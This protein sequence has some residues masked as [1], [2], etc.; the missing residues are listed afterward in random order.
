VVKRGDKNLNA[1]EAI[2]VLL[3]VADFFF[4]IF[5][6]PCV[7]V[8]FTVGNVDEKSKELIKVTHDA[9]MAA[10][11]AVQPGTMFRDFGEI[12]TKAVGKSGFSVVRAV[13]PTLGEATAM[14]L[15]PRCVAHML[16]CL[17]L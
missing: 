6:T 11:A 17:L 3:F 16:I 12:I 4:F 15:C 8:Q 5:F 10:V 13:R 7:A 14:R 2:A 9:L 1:A